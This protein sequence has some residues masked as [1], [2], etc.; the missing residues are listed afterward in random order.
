MRFSNPASI[1]RL[2]FQRLKSDPAGAAARALLGDAERSVIPATDIGRAPLPP[3]PFLAYK[4]GPSTNVLGIDTHTAAWWIYDDPPQ[5]TY[6]VDQVAAALAPAY[7]PERGA[8]PLPSP[9]GP[10]RLLG[11]SEPRED[12]ALGLRYRRLDLSIDA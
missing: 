10:A 12:L 1:H 11:L 5:G 8:P 2:A 9:A 7:L 3:R 4:P 6:R